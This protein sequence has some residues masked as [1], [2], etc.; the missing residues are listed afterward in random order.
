MTLK[1][2]SAKKVVVEEKQKKSSKKVKEKLPQ[3]SS[4]YLKDFRVMNSKQE[5]LQNMIY[6]KDITICNGPSGT[7]KTIVS[8]ATAFNMLGEQYKRIVIVK[9]VTV[10][11]GEE[12]GFLKGDMATKMEPFMVSFTG[13]IDKLMGKRGA[14]EELIGKGIVEILPLAYIRGFTQDDCI[15]IADEIQNITPKLFKSLITRIGSNCKYILLGDVEQIDKKKVGDSCLSKVIEIF[16]D[17]PII[18]SIEFTDAE[19]VR[20]PIIPQILEKLRENGI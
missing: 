1:G 3:S 4:M 17:S 6:D 14:A 7:G 11:E 5:E 20:N 8:L 16:K 2:K 10:V 12:I 9:S 19:C 13:N 18:G 15:V